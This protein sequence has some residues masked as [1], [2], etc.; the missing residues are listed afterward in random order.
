ML[1]GKCAL[2]TGSTSGIGLAYAKALAAEGCA[3]T[4]NGV[5]DPE[6]IE[7]ATAAVS[8][9]GDGRV[10]FSPADMRKP[11]EIRAL[12]AGAT[13]AMGR[14]DILINNAGIQHV[15]P[16]EDF[17]DDQWD[18]IIAINLSSS[19]H[20]IKATLPQMR[21]RDWGRIVNTSSVQGLV[22]SI[23]KA[24]YVAAKHGLIGL[25]KMVALETAESGI[26]CNAICPGS[27]D[28]AL[29]R[30]Q[31]EKFASEAGLSVEEASRRRL[32]EKQPSMK[33]VGVD[34]LAALAVFLCSDAASQ[35]TGTALPMDGGWTAQ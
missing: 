30:W 12:V 20:T 26:T 18:A 7:A 24:A 19:F 6:T 23:H 29:S 17:P 10:H 34:Q 27:T 32:A 13:E 9:A 33:Q 1:D 5:A 25:T 16:I 22:A 35:M 21:A 2:V 15:S 3:V 8:A 11:D 31:T 4:L 28:T 14:V